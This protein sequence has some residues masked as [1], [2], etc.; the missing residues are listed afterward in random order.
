MDPAFGSIDQRP[1]DE[2]GIQP[3]AAQTTQALTA[4]FML[5]ASQIFAVTLAKG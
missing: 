2:R 1:D 4:G 3:A 5:Q